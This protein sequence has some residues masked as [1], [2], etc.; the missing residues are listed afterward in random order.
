MIKEDLVKQTHEFSLSMGEEQEVKTDD[1]IDL[2]IGN[3][4]SDFF[5]NEGYEVE[6]M[7]DKGWMSFKK[8]I[9][10]RSDIIGNINNYDG[11]YRYRVKP[12]ESMRVNQDVYDMIY[13]ETIKRERYDL[14]RATLDDN[15]GMLILDGRKVEIINE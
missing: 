8:N 6:Y 9:N 10:E 1:W 14:L 2:D 15:T 13:Q 12:L 4:P 7:W 3:I 11:E 5:V